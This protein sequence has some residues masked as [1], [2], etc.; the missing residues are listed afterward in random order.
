MRVSFSTLPPVLRPVIIAVR[1]RQSFRLLV[2]P[3]FG[4][5]SE[6]TIKADQMIDVM[7][8]I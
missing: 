7:R 6:R 4:F 5:E 8:F 1:A 3:S 2:I